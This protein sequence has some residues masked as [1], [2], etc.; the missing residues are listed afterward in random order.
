MR[1]PFLHVLDRDLEG[2]TDTQYRGFLHAALLLY[3][4][5]GLVQVKPI[6]KRAAL[7]WTAYTL[8]TW[9]RRE[10][11]NIKQLKDATS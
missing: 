2:S 6:I 8:T 3:C 7:V 9:W 11:N 5:A 4:T 10:Q 1:N